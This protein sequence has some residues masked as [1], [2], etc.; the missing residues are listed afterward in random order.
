MTA[1]RNG[2]SK[3]RIFPVTRPT[4]PCVLVRRLAC[5]YTGRPFPRILQPQ[6]DCPME[7]MLNIAL[8]A[9]RKAALLIERS[10][11]RL[12]LVQIE[13]KRPNDFV[14]DVDR[15]AEKEIISQLRKTYPD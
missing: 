9:A 13:N 8:R 6:T 10:Y 4:S 12:D 7:P 15:S 14:T 11:D 3:I 5:R 1:T 2:E